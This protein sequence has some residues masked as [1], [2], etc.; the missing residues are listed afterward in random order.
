M[1][2]RATKPG[3]HLKGVRKEKDLLFFV[4]KE[5]ITCSE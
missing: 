4:Q 5:Q 3:P 1:Q 2:G